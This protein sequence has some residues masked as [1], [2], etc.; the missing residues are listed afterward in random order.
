MGENATFYKRE[1]LK[2]ARRQPAAGWDYNTRGQSLSQVE[3]GK[4]ALKIVNLMV[5]GKVVTKGGAKV[6]HGR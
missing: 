6:Y 2:T 5:F 4:L 3:N 1:F